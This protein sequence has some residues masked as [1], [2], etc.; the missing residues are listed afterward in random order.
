M[1]IPK[2]ASE[3]ESK[4]RMKLAMDD[5]IEAFPG[6]AVV[7]VIAPFDAPRGARTNYIG[8]GQ[9]EDIKVLLKELLARW[10][11]RAHDAPGRAQ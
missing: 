2:L 5:L 6:C 9:R 4:L 10:E 8:N 3:A 1:S 7:L 11:G